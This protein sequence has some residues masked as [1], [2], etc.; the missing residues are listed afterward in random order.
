MP[1]LGLPVDDNL[2]WAALIALAAT[3]RELIGL[4]KLPFTRQERAVA[5][6][7]QEASEL[8]SIMTTLTDMGNNFAKA[9]NSANE[10]TERERQRRLEREEEHRANVRALEKSNLEALEQ[11]K[12]ANERIDNLQEFIDKLKLEVSIKDNNVEE[13]NKT[14]THLNETIE[15]QGTRIAALEASEKASSELVRNKDV[16]ITRLQA[17]IAH[18]E[19]EVNRLKM[20]QTPPEPPPLSSALLAAGVQPEQHDPDSLLETITHTERTVPADEKHPI[21]FPRPD[22]DDEPIPPIAVD[23]AK[24]EEAD[25]GDDDE[26][27]AQQERAA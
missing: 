11:Y 4:I 19:A 23:P 14:I 12:N 16:E 9:L 1:D 2:L 13:L 27:E 25:E 7:V 17:R 5:A 6:T 18:L 24:A 20:Q 21:P 10:N 3:W 22:D 8:R 15:A 26:D